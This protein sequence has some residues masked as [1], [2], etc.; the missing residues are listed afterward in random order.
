MNKGIVILL[1]LGLSLS[2]FT[3]EDSLDLPCDNNDWLQTKVKELKKS[4]SQ[5][6]LIEQYEYEGQVVISVN[7]CVGCADAM[8][9]VY[10]CSGNELCKFGGIAGYNDCPNF[11]VKAKFIKVIFKS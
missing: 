6:A 10:D 9:V 11:S 1:T 4:G 8:T 7:N 5:K 3:C 2:A